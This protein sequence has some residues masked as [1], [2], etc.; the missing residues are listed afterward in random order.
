MYILVYIH[1]NSIDSTHHLVKVT[2][3]EWRITILLNA[4]SKIKNQKMGKKNMNWQKSM[5][6]EILKNV[7][8]ILYFFI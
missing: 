7:N 5:F 4:Q 8:N 1:V 6:V 2:A 3:H